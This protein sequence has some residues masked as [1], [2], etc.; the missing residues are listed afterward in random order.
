MKVYIRNCIYI[1]WQ[2]WKEVGEYVP[3]FYTICDWAPSPFDGDL[4]PRI[5]QVHV[6]EDVHYE[7]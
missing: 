6:V 3:D 4:R 2:E 1:L 5:Y 7:E